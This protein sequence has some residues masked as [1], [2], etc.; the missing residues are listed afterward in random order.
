[1]FS[2]LIIAE[3]KSRNPCHRCVSGR[4]R[5]TPRLAQTSKVCIVAQKRF[6][7]MGL[8]RR[9]SGIMQACRREWVG[10][11]RGGR[12]LCRL[13]AML[14]V[15]LVA[16]VVRAQDAGLTPCDFNATGTAADFYGVPGGTILQPFKGV[17]QHKGVDV[18]QKR[19][20]PVFLNLRSSIPLSELNGVRYVMF[21][22]AAQ[23]CEAPPC[24]R[25]ERDLMGLGFAATGDAH[26]VDARVFVQP[27]SAKQEP[28]GDDY[29][30]VAG[31][32][33][34]YEYPDDR[35]GKHIFTIYVEYEHLITPHYPPRLDNGTF[36]DAED[37]P[38]AHG[39][40]EGCTGF[41][42]RMQDASTLSANEIAAHPL[43]G[44]LGATE[45]PHVHIQ[46]AFANESAGYLR[47]YFIEPNVVLTGH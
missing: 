4:F 45:T 38:I 31:I 37:R 19:G 10:G 29:G 34:H 2:R 33:A 40:Y 32:A 30:G 39:A 36:V 44:F 22:A 21:T 35:G 11:G 7:D 42:T 18:A 17:H 43:V 47:N 15:S 20:T 27:W 3:I 12:A 9:T 41:G 1:V 14:L 26:L 6:A 28:V 24:R 13:A 46:A 8:T 25:V 23:P 16:F 5:D